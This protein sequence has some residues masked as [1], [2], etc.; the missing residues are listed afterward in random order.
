MKMK[1]T[2]HRDGRVSVDGNTVG[3]IAVADVMG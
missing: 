2:F 3:T 1:T